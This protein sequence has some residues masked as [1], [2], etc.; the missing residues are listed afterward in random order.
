MLVAVARQ[1]TALPLSAPETARRFDV[2]PGIG[3][4]PCSHAILTLA[5][6]RAF[7]R[8]PSQTSAPPCRLTF[9]RRSDCG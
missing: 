9:G 6:G 8:P 1:A 7:Q 5:F 3:R 4:P 2:A